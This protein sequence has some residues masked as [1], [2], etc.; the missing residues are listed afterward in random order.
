MTLIQTDDD[1]EPI[2]AV[3]E[4]ALERAIDICL[5]HKSPSDQLQM[6]QKLADDQQDWWDVATF[7]SYSC[8]VDALRLKP[9]QKPP[10][11]IDDMEGILAY[12]DDGVMGLYAAATLLKRLLTAGLSQY[13]PDPLG[14][15]KAA[16]K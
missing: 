12:G 13:E 11:W 3:D 10:C 4:E 6:E 16:G 15:L 2:P 8:Q 5:K 1:Y 7:A 14:A 9:W